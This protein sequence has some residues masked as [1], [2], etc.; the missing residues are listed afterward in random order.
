MLEISWSLSISTIL[1]VVDLKGPEIF[2]PFLR[3]R[4][5]IVGIGR[6][7]ERMMWRRKDKGK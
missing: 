7:W 5:R 2:G 1:S 4:F 3:E 6:I